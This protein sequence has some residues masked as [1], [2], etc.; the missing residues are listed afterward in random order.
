MTALTDEQ[1]KLELKRMILEETGKDD[2]S[3]EDI[4]DDEALFGPDAPLA[5][6]SLDGLQISVALKQRY[7]V[8][9]NDSKRLRRIMA[10]INSLTDFLR[11]R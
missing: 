8:E 7:G 5:L 1:L 11:T 10:D 3:P 9:I 6:D 2:L 4:S